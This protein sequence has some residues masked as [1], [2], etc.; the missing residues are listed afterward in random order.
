MSYTP[1][2]PPEGGSEGSYGAPQDPNGGQ[3]G[4]GQQ[5]PGQYPAGPGYGYGQPPKT[6]Q[7]AIWALV[8][9][10]LGIVCCG[11]V[12]GIPALILGNMRQEGDRGE[13]RQRRPGQAW[14]RPASC[15]ASSP[16]CWVS[17]DS[18]SS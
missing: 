12:A 7:K 9:G 14:P 10:I 6:N 11:F 17:W 18:C 13:R 2:P 5:P 16:S 15:S 8:L 1:P 3:Y 4:G